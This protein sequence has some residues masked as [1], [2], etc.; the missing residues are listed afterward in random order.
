MRI[1]YASTRYGEVRKVDT[2]GPVRHQSGLGREW[3]VRGGAAAHARRPPS[4]RPPNTRDAPTP[5]PSERYDG[6]RPTFTFLFSASMASG[7]RSNAFNSAVHH[8]LL[9]V[10]RDL[11]VLSKEAEGLRQHTE[12]RPL[13]VV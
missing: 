6:Q 1:R 2:G 5:K 7:S 12:E 11:C 10:M 8:K 13:V 3:S 9:Q 4:P